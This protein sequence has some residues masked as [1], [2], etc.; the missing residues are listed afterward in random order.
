MGGTLH[1]SQI[2]RYLSSTA[3]LLEK[4]LSLSYEANTFVI[5]CGGRDNGW[6]L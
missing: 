1:N 6:L 4:C 5:G 2:D 3:F